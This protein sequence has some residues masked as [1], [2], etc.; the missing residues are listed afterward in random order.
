MVAAGPVPDV[1]TPDIL[2]GVFGVLGRTERD[3]DGVVRIT[4]AAQPL[5]VG[6]HGTAYSQT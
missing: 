6:P 2:R 5:A 1:L 4:Y 3:E